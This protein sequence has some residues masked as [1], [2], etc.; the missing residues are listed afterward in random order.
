VSWV[1]Q[2]RA[3]HDGADRRRGVTGQSPRQAIEAAWRI[4]APRL[5]AQKHE[6]LAPAMDAEHRAAA[7]DPDAALDDAL[8]TIAPSPVV[9]LNRA[10]AVATA[11]G[12][13]AGLEIVDRLAADDAL[14]AYHL[15]PAVRGEL[16]SRLG[17]REEACSEFARAASLTRNEREQAALLRRAAARDDTR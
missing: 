16:L 15:L 2:V 8:A 13:A 6:E 7:P 12:P 17:R 3:G 14:A 1:S 4:E 10:V 5:V 9:E 11:F